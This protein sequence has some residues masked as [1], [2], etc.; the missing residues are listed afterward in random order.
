[1]APE[2]RHTGKILPHGRWVPRASTVSVSMTLGI[3]LVQGDPWVISVGFEF[4][5]LAVRNLNKH[6]WIGRIQRGAWK[7]LLRKLADTRVIENPPTW[8][9][10]KS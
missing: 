5:L 7:E 6:E 9:K 4:V 8:T 3:F 1:M 2:V 10:S